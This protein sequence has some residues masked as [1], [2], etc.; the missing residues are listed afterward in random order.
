MYSSVV[1]T[2]VTVGTGLARPQP[3]LVS[4]IIGDVQPHN[5]NQK[6]KL[7]KP[8]NEIQKLKIRIKAK[9]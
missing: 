1:L 6:A 9:G 2:I 4:L 3:R 5:S 8:V 7:K